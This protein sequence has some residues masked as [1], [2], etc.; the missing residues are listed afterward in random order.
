MVADVCMEMTCSQTKRRV[1]CLILDFAKLFLA[2]ADEILPQAA[3]P[4]GGI[5][6]VSTSGAVLQ[7]RFAQPQRLVKCA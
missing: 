6:I 7:A 2:I 3:V 5:Y 4:K 1:K